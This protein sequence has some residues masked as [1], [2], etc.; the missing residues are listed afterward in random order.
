MRFAAASGRNLP[1]FTPQGLKSSGVTTNAGSAAD[2]VSVGSIYGSL[3]DSAPDYAAIV[4]TAAKNRAEERVAAMN[5]EATM[6]QAG[7]SAAGNVAA[8]KE[9]AKGMKAQAGATKK[10]GM[11]SAIGGIAAAGIGLLSDEETKHTIDELEYAC[12]ILRE[13]RPVT[14]FYKEEY[15]AHPERMHYGFIA[16][17]YQKVMPDA[18]YVDGSIN[19]LCIDPIELISILVR[20][21]QELQERVTH[22][23]V[24]NALVSV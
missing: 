24:K 18:T 5:A 9:Q 2:A 4:G 1:D 7:I 17:E 14:F 3:R 21:N 22:L 10:A 20:A 6:T 13:L 15:S 12:D 16:Q 23:E 8:A 11:M 19:K